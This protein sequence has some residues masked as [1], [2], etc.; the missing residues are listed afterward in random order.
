MGFPFWVP[1]L[2]LITRFVFDV[3][4]LAVENKFVLSFN[5]RCAGLA[6]PASF[7][8]SEEILEVQPDVILTN[9]LCRSDKR[10]K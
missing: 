6:F 8:R 7:P 9:C 5:L 4:E 3:N 2:R 10:K 1:G